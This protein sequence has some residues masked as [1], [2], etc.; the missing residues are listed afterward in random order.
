MSTHAT[1]VALERETRAELTGRI[2]PYWSERAVDPVHGGFFGYIGPD[3]AADPDAPRAA[4]LNSRILWTFS[5]AGRVLG[6][7]S[8]HHVADRAADVL[9]RRFLDA[10]DGGVYWAVDRAGRPVDDRKHV[11]AQAFAVYGLAE[12]HRATGREESLREAVALFRLIEGR[13]RDAA[14]GGYREAFSRDWSPLED[15][16]LGETDLNAPK[17]ANTHLHLVEAYA[18]LLRTWR[19][20][21][22]ADRLRALVELFVDRIVDRSSGHL[23]PFFDAD[24]TPRSGIVSYGHD[25]EASWLLS[26][27]AAALEDRTLAGRVDAAAL[28]LAD[29]VLREGFDPMGGVFYLADPAGTVDREKEWWPQAEAIVGFLH[30][31]QRTGRADFLAAARDTWA[32]IK[33]YMLDQQQGEWYRRVDRDGTLQPQHEKVGPWKGPYHNARACLEVMRRASGG[34]S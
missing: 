33:A 25:I 29:A 5:A 10:A 19:D 28:L 11:Y 1:L 18:T 32:F 9:R 15:A 34:R 30:A 21:E 8:L 7:S 4:N 31:Y 14:C 13:A 17:S 12:H 16:R 20:P 6:D 3:G 26:D 23:R 2:L 22:L 27:A 24:W